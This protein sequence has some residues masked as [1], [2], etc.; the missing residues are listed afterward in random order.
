MFMLLLLIMYKSIYSQVNQEWVARFNG[1]A[2]SSDV[3]ESITVDNF[4]NIYITGYTNSGGSAI[5]Q[6][7]CTIKYNSFGMQQWTAIY[8][9]PANN[10]D[11]SY[12]ITLDSSGNVYVTGSSYTNNTNFDICTIKY[13]SSG[14]QQWVSR[15]DGVA[16]GY[17][18]PQS[19]K[20]DD[21]GNVYIA[22][23][24]EG[25]SEDYCTIKYNSAGIQQWIVRYN[26]PGNNRDRVND[27]NIDVNGNLY[28]TGES[29]GIGTQKDICTIKYNSSGIQQWIARYN[30]VAN[31]FDGAKK[32]TL[33]IA[34]N[35]YVT[36]YTRGI[37]T[38]SD[39]CTIKYNSNGVQQWVTTYVGPTNS[40]EGDIAFSIATD[41]VGNTYVTGIS[42]GI[43]SHEDIVTMKYNSSGVQQWIQ[44]FNGQAGRNDNAKSITIDGNS[45]VYVAGYTYV[46]S[47]ADYIILKYNSS[48]VQQWSQT[49]NG[50]GNGT[51]RVNAVA[52]DN[53][54][55][56][57]AT[58][59]SSYYGGFSDYDIVTIKY[60]Q[61]IGI[62]QI[63][64]EVPKQYSLS[65][66]YPNPFNPT[67]QIEF[68]IPRNNELVKLTVFDITG[69]EISTLVNQQLNAGTYKVDFTGEYL[70]SGLYFYKLV[71]WYFVATRKMILLK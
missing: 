64:T 19:I 33:D 56:I 49:Y 13:N 52:I 29:E 43:A 25:I 45:N 27:M 55:N 51:D 20:V 6:D 7:F 57:F 71:T 17:D 59:Y 37:S 11:G 12:A 58:G 1:S 34:G 24:S 44:R 8:N 53:L 3:G 16:N 66:N 42:E 63:S 40:N 14:I 15:Y 41:I 31:S 61:T 50:L 5:S 60:S 21:I 9:S 23:T 28:V 69:K 22:G 26:G 46:D 4:G 47:T 35:I 2:D 48:G 39:Y 36:G 54:N 65:Q 67:T 68:S 18:Y 70:A 30:G 62:H 10:S 32:M 38:G